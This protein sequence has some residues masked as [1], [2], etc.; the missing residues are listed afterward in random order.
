MPAPRTARAIP[1]GRRSIA[2]SVSTTPAGA[3]SPTGW[4]GRASA[5]GSAGTS[6]RSTTTPPPTSRRSGR[7]SGC[8]ELSDVGLCLDTGH[9]L[10]G[11]G[12]PVAAIRDWADR[13]NHVHLKD[14]R[15]STLEEIVAEAAPVEEIWRRQAFCALGDGDIDVARRARRARPR[16]ATRAGWWSSRTSCLTRPIPVS[17]RA[18]PASQ[19]RVPARPWAVT[20]DDAG[21]DCPGG[22]RPHGTGSPAGVGGIPGHRADRRGRAGGRDRRR[23]GGPWPAGSHTRPTSCWLRAAWMASWW[24][25]RRTSTRRW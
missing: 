13:I 10:L 24:P 3:G 21:T 20:H 16:S 12:E 2:A 11:R 17:R 18:R 15:L 1:G 6:R 7:S 5:A 9:L 8:S 14:A 19:S 22:C 4:P 23:A 25:L